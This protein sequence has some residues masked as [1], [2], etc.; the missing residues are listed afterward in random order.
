MEPKGNVPL[1]TRMWCAWTNCMKSNCSTQFLKVLDEIAREIA[2]EI[3]RE[4]AR[5]IAW[6]IACESARMKLLS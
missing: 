2:Q 1:H 6:E 3:T 5:E 4:I